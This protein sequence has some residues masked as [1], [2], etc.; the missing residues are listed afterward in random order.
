MS[1]EVVTCIVF[2]IGVCLSVQQSHG[3]IVLLS[4]LLQE[5]QKTK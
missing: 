3:F 2:E 1:C 5:E 4:N